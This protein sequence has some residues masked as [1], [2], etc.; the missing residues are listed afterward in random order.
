MQPLMTLEPAGARRARL[1]LTV[2]ALCLVAVNVGLF[3]PA[4]LNAQPRP[5]L[6]PFFPAEHP[7]GAWGFDLRSAWEYLKALGLRRANLDPFRVSVELA[8][9]TA[10]VV[11]WPRAVWLRRAVVACAG[12]ALLLLSYHH[13]FRAFFLRAPALWEDWRLLRNLFHYVADLWSWRWAAVAAG[14]AVAFALV[15]AALSWALSTLATHGPAPVKRALF[16]LAG[17]GLASVAWF[18]A[19]R[20]DP[21]ARLVT[22]PLAENVR[23]SLERK[24]EFEALAV[25]EPDHRYREFSRVRLERKPSVALMM[26]EAYGEL[27][28]ACDTGPAYRALMLRMQE[29]LAAAGYGSRTAY[30]RAPISGGQS[31][32]SI[33]TVQLGMRIDTVRKF[34]LVENV[35]ADTPSLTRFFEGQGYF[36]AAVQ[37]GNSRRPGLQRFDTWHRKLVLDAEDLDYRGLRYVGWMGIPDQ[38]T[39]GFIGERLPGLPRPWLLFSMSVST[40]H[41]W[42]APFVYVNDWK[43]LQDPALDTAAAAAPWQPIDERAAIGEERRGYFHTLEYE[44]RGLADLIESQRGEDTVFIVLGDHQ[45]KLP[46]NGGKPMSFNTPLHIIS[47]DPALLERFSAAG[48]SDGLLVSPGARA[49]LAHEG[50]FSLFV[51]TFAAAWGDASHTPLERMPEGISLSTLYR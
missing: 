45:P 29:R 21:V 24:R 20:E 46:C 42:S 35:G 41:P 40:H 31:W 38:Y 15:L 39:L 1:R 5:D 33:A 49:P 17:L 27:A 30:S 16:A 14:G 6:T 2:A 8:V 26:I 43:A 25:G 3:L 4:Y 37:P 50:L 12:A 44:W 11:V 10:A 48:F 18:G 32:L 22:G 23:V 7:Y 28:A 51:V 19:E 34:A 9:A 13:T 47:R 36:T